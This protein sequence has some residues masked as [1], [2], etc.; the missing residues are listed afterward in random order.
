[1]KDSILN[2]LKPEIHS[3]YSNVLYNYNDFLEINRWVKRGQG[4]NTP[5]RLIKYPISNKTNF[6]F[7][8]NFLELF[9]FRFTDNETSIKHKPVSHSTFLTMKQKR[10]KRR[11]TIPAR[12]EFEKD[13]N[14]NN[15]KK[16]R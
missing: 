16:I 11:K 4:T 6:D 12:V 5:I 14:G 3:V 9:R 1:L 15:T 13:L 2:F 8:N 10:Y 7:N